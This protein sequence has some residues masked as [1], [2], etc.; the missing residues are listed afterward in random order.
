MSDLRVGYDVFSG[1]SQ[2]GTD[3]SIPGTVQVETNK[4]S[5]YRLGVQRLSDSFYYNAT[6]KLFQVGRPAEADELLIPGSDSDRGIHPAIR[7]LA[8]RIPKEALDGITAAGVKVM[9]Y[10]LGDQATA[11]QKSVTLDYKPV[12]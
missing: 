3:S 2:A 9:A 10:A 7:R 5:V 6:T 1:S 8:A 4:K 11:D 12:T